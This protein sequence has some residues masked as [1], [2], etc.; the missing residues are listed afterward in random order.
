MDRLVQALLAGV[1]GGRGEHAD[2]AGAHRGLVRQYV[3]EHVAGDDDVELAGVADQLH[4]GVVD[5]HVAERDVGIFGGDLDHHVAPELRGFED[6]GLVDRAELAAPGARGLEADPG[7]AR[8]LVLVVGHD[9][10]ALAP[11]GG[12]LAHALLAEIDVAVGLADDHQVDLGGDLGAQGGGVGELLEQAGRAQIGEQLE[13]LAQAQDRLLGAQG[14][15]EAVAIGMAD[16]A[17]QD[18][19]GAPGDLEGGGGERVAFGD[20]G[21]LA[22]QPDLIFERV[23]ADDFEHAHRFGDDFRTDAVSGE[24]GNQHI[25]PFSYILAGS[26]ALMRAPVQVEGDLPFLPGTGRR[27]IRAMV[28]GDRLPTTSLAPASRPLHR[29]AA[30]LHV[31]G[32]NGLTPAA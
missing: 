4:R 2:R 5:I 18:R 29:F 16:R 6:I 7:D 22:D 27:T 11:A 30:P 9:V 25:Q 14:P 19:V 1:E 21:G 26:P 12:G 28:E 10:I 15:I 23:A 3:A 31:P 32:R 24:Q 8:H 20:I 13:L 17:E